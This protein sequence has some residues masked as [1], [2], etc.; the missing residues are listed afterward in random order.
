MDKTQFLQGVSLFSDLPTGTLT[1]LAEKMLELNF[2]RG[3][4][5]CTEN[6]KG[7]ALFILKSGIVEISV[8][9]GPEKKILA[10]LKRGD[11]FGEMAIF[12]GDP[13]SATVQA[14]ADVS[15]LG[16]TKTDFE[17]EVR[18]SPAIA[19]ELLKTLSRR[20]TKQNLAST[21]DGASARGKL[22]F[23]TASQKKAGK[24]AV[25]RDLASALNDSF[26]GKVV[27]L[28]PNVTN[29][30]VALSLGIEDPCDLA[31]E[32]VSAESVT[33]DKYLVKTAEGLWVLP[34]QETQNTVYPLREA[35]HHILLNAL[36]DRF[37]Y[38]VVDSS[39][40]MAS[41]NRHLMR[42]ADR[43]V[44]LLSGSQEDLK[45]FLDPFHNLVVKNNHIDPRRLLTIANLDSE[46]AGQGLEEKL[47]SYRGD[48]MLKLP[49]A[50]QAHQTAATAR[51][52]IPT[53]LPE[54]EWTKAIEALAR[55]IVL[56]HEVDVFFP[57]DAENLETQKREAKDFELELEKVFS[58]D[59]ATEEVEL[60]D[61]LGTESGPGLRIHCRMTS[62]EL[63]AG[64]DPFLQAVTRLRARLG[65]DEI[66]IRVDGR[67]SIL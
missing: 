1:P 56:E 57:R 7:D 53:L 3:E 64:M 37:E 49:F 55:R 39:S 61:F 20:L 11:Y 25:A 22:I 14:I 12:T 23:L 38:V 44:V 16:L 15:V 51:Q 47:G 48:L 32:L 35:H 42:S 21:K 36:L 6:D 9:E 8:G 34:P 29:A 28:D 63:R 19:L 41:F 62:E 66:T 17:V 46:D 24:T 27:F 2:P 43:L 67:P 30:D 13:R 5:I 18:R 65:L 40:T 50:P 31:Q 52:A 59:V 60:Q 45:S 4:R 54:A 58:E 10:Y 26:E 33:L